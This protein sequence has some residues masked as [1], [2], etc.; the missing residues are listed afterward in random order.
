VRVTDWSGHRTGTR[1]LFRERYGDGTGSH[2]HVHGANLGFRAAAY[3][4]AGGFP[5]AATA[6]DHA[7][8]TALEATGSRIL[9][10]RAV[11]VRTSARPRARA[12][13]GFSHYLTEIAGQP[14]TAITA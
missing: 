3:L 2:T 4:T 7:L 13:H 5:A 9:R 14:D 6:E 1:S 8:V 11:T 10:T 12:P